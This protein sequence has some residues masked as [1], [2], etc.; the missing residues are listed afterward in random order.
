MAV[1]G[2]MMWWEVAILLFLRLLSRGLVGHGM[3]LYLGLDHGFG[4]I[5]GIVTNVLLLYGSND[6]LIVIG[7]S[8]IFLAAF[9]MIK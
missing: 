5:L 8:G 7:Y 2:L 6:P 3:W 9:M 1:W 4:R